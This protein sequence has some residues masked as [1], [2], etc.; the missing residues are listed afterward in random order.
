MA[1]KRKPPPL[2]AADLRARLRAKWPAPEWVV[3]DEVRSCTGY[4]RAERYADVLALSTYPSRGLRLLGCELKS[5]RSDVLR[6][7]RHPDKADGIQRWCHGWFL[8]VGRADLVKP[9]ELPPKWGLMVPYRAGLK[10]VKDAPALTPETWPTDFVASLVRTAYRQR[11][12][13]TDIQKAVREA[14]EQERRQAEAEAKRMWGKYHAL[15]GVVQTF[16]RLTG[17]HL[18]EYVSDEMVREDAEKF[19]RM[20]EM[21]LDRAMDFAAATAKRFEDVAERLRAIVAMEDPALEGF[22]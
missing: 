21:K 11:P 15:K 3:L 8:V 20:R 16:N 18:S 1:R 19:R 12:S 17:I 6:E 4:S 2:R 14:R 9:D 7:L 5:S 10:V 22:F 13:A